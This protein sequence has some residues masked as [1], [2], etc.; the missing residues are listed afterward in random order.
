L[1]RVVEVCEARVVELEV[2]TAEL[3]QSPDRPNVLLCRDG[4]A[5]L[6]GEGSLVTRLEFV[7]QF[8]VRLE[9]RRRQILN[10]QTVALRVVVSAS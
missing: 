10:R 7:H 8:V 9:A 3:S 4:R 5:S 1:V 2:G 6:F